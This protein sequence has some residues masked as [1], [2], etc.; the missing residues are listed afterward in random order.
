MEEYVWTEFG[1]RKYVFSGRSG[2]NRP[3]F[4]VVVRVF[5]V[6]GEPK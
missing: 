6:G 3:I 5:G 2:A 4:S 1:P